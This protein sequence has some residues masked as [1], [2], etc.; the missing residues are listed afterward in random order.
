MNYPGRAPAREFVPLTSRIMT[1]V[2][3]ET[4][5]EVPFLSACSLVGNS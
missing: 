1:L 2:W 3:E 4:V 5:S